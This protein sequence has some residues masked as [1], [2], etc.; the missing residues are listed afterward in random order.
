MQLHCG[1]CVVRSWRATDLESLVRHANNRKIWAQLRDRFPH[2]YTLADGRAWLAH[3][4][5]ARPETSFAIEVD[6]EAAGGIGLMLGTDVERASAEVGYW[7][8][9]AF[10]GRGIATAALRG[11]TAYAFETF[12]LCR[13]F[14]LPFAGNVASRRVLEKSGFALE[15]TLRRSAIKD[16]RVTDQAQY[17]LVRE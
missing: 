3:V 16:G 9:E 12:G 7:L 6:A 1:L 5:Q 2:P 10:W 15:G 17:A 13:I 14:A 11:L 8:G 4:E